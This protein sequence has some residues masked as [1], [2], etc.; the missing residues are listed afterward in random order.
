LLSFNGTPITNL[1]HLIR[2]VQSC[3][4]EW[5]RFELDDLGQQLVLLNAAEVAVRIYMCTYILSRLEKCV[6][7]LED[8]WTSIG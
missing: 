6:S 5:M 8:G 1:R 2:L 4:S 7:L 3:E